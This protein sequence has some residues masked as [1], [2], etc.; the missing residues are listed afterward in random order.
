M[1]EAW[2]GIRTRPYLR[3]IFAVAAVLVAFALREILVKALAT[4]LP[5]FV[6]LYPAVAIV[7]ILAGWRQ[8]LLATLLASVAAQ[9]WS[10]DA[11]GRFPNS[12]LSDYIVLACFVGMGA[13]VSAASAV[14]QRNAQ[15]LAAIKKE[16]A[17]QQATAS[18]Q[19]SEAQFETLAN[20]I[21]QLCWIANPN[22]WATWYNR[23]WY[24]YTGAT[25]QQAEAWGWQDYVAPDVL[26]QVLKRWNASISRGEPI[27]EVFPLKGGDGVFRPFLTRVVPVKDADGKVICWFGTNTDIS[28]QKKAELELRKSKEKLE[29]AAEVAAIGEWELD[30]TSN[31]AWRSLRHAQIF[32]YKDNSSEWSYKAFI[33]H[34]LPEHRAKTDQTINASQSHGTVDYETQIR[35]VDGEIRW[36]WIR[37]RS[38]SDDSGATRM[39]G[40]VM[41]ITE[42]KRAEEELRQNREWLKVTLSS[43][44][45]AV[46]AT[47]TDGRVTFMNPV[48]AALTGW[49][50]EDA[51]GKPVHSIFKI[52]S[53]KSSGTSEAVKHSKDARAFEPANHSALLATTGREIPIED[54]A[55]PIKDSAGQVV[56]EVLV[57]H[58][59]TAKRESEDALQRYE[60]LAA[61]SRDTI[62]FMRYEDGQILEANAAAVHA[63]GYTHEELLRL[64]IHD[65][66]PIDTQPLTLQMAKAKTQGI[67][68]ETVHRRKD[69]S[70]FPVEVSSQG[71][72]IDGVETLVSV[73]RD[74]TERKQVEQSLLRSEK[75]V[76]AG[77]MAAAIAH[78]INN[79][80]EAVTNMLYL[81]TVGDSIPEPAKQ[82]LEAADTELRRIAHITRQSL[83]F[84]RESNAPALTSLNSVLDS[85]VDLLRSKIR[86]KQA[87]VQRKSTEDI[88]IMAVSGELRQVFANLLANSVEALEPN[89]T[90]TLRV[91][92]GRCDSQGYRQVR[93][94][95]ADNGVGISSYS[96]KRLFEP[97][98]STKG[99]VGTG[100]GLWVCKELVDK[101]GGTIRVRSREQGKHQGTI[102]TVVLP[103]ELAQSKAA[104]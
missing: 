46:L 38:I 49:R 55:A 2:D 71:A 29:L 54:S 73:I 100:L 18:L 66:R 101:H 41:D 45:D 97:F 53:K 79:P 80:L 69:G 75:L 32:G 77:R 83:G 60:L 85:A 52:V 50:P 16:Q 8:G 99:V 36:I 96:K 81:A 68:F 61:H 57:F 44:G 48:A 82:Y 5:P 76:F 103:A 64:K 34:V 7:A 30:L 51:Q 9:F 12:R 3:Y 94:T 13:L 33:E 84:Y 43:I 15:R 11:R 23:R 17:L 89:G 35:R 20:S 65:L 28:E 88:E 62:L 72:I 27:D 95:I 87:S 78:E 21:Q 37:G 31:K 1:I 4:D 74:I 91:S 102:V 39:F 10:F 90:I 25:P 56:G 47:D 42:N 70:T 58:D 67:L 98:F 40:T 26:P 14:Y 19:R 63:Y 93:V 24:E 92:S 22:G 104:K 86:A 59:V 6:T